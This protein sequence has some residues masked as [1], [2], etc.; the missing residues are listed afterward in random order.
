MLNGRVTVLGAERHPHAASRLAE[1]WP[2]LEWIHAPQGRAVPET[3]PTIELL[4]APAL[5]EGAF[6]IEVDARAAPRIR[7]QGGPYSGVIYGVEELVQ[8]LGTSEPG[9]I[10]VPVTSLER[11]P[12]LTYRT[13]WT[14][15]HSTNWELNQIGQQEIGVFNP[16]GKPPGGFLKDYK[17][18]VDFCSQNQIA[19][20]VIYG[21]FRDSHGGVEAAQEL[22]RYAKARGVR[23]LPGVAIGAY[24]GVYWEGNNQYNLATWLTENPGFAADME[25]GVG[26]QLQDL[27]FPLNFPRSDYTRTACP[28]EPANIEWM[29]DALAWLVETVDPGGINIEGGD[30][31][32]CGCPRCVTRRGEREAAS[33]RDNDAEFWSHADMADNFP[34]LFNAASSAGDDLWLYCELQ[35]DNLLDP[36]A[37]APLESLPAGG[38]YQHTFNRGYWERAKSELTPEHVAALPTAKNVIR[39]QFACQW[40]GDERTERYAFNA[41]VF[42]ELSKKAAEVDMQG[43]TVWGEPS[44][45]HVSAELSYLAFGRFGYDPSLTWEQF[46]ATDV[47]SRVGG[48][49]EAE[50]FIG[51]MQE[52]DSQQFMAPKRLL[53]IRDEAVDAGRSQ[54]GDAVRRWLWLADR[55]NQRSYMGY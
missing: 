19:A 49:A 54:S 23:V 13:F 4:D 31:G 30:Y 10:R 51:L 1:Q 9:G 45:F 26:F 46:V 22:T 20:I 3:M 55:A 11:R 53:S 8:R 6:R 47:A 35:W 2:Q 18:M 15:D 38:I 24:G 32:V 52:L 17:R 14:W 25:R 7:I 21:F 29:A 50:S 16:Y 28:S 44:P 36:A 39:S 34:K 5:S 12:K 43:L 27:A 33:R 42:A 37:H 48:A 41:P 40:N